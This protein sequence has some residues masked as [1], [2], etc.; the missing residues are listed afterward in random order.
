M[1]TIAHVLREVRQ[2]K[3]ELLP[4]LFGL[5]LDFR[6][7]VSPISQRTYIPPGNAS[8]LHT[9]L[10]LVQELSFL[11]H[12]MYVL[13][14][15]SSDSSSVTSVGVQGLNHLFDRYWGMA[16]SPGIEVGGSTNKGIAG[17]V[18]SGSGIRC[19]NPLKLGFSC[20]LSFGNDRHIDDISTPLSVHD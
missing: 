11:N 17:E 20:E 6:Q 10:N 4:G 16:G 19:M 7:L 5:H 8:E 1:A 9:P 14:D 2:D 15:T 13:Q 12:I 3:R 18:S